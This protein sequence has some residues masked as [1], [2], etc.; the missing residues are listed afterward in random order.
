MATSDILMSIGLFFS[1]SGVLFLL[2]WMF[3]Q[4]E[5][6]Q[7]RV[8]FDHLEANYHRKDLADEQYKHIMES[9]EV[10]K[11]MLSDHITKGK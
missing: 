4:A 7:Q 10:I 11:V 3:K 2:G 9:I 1:T 6:M 5:A 8:T